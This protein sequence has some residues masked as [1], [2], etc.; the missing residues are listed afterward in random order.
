MRSSSGAED[1][2][3][4]AEGEEAYGQRHLGAGTCGWRELSLEP[5]L[6]ELRLC[7]DGLRVLDFLV[8]LHAD[9]L[10]PSHPISSKS[11]RQPAP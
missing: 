10:S 4:R 8:T 9:A 2:V 3:Q 5:E 6:G 1:A 11:T 7:F